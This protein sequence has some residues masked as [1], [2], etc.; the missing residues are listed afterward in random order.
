MPRRRGEKRIDSAAQLDE[1]SDRQPRKRGERCRAGRL[2]AHPRRDQGERVVRLHDDQMVL[3]GKPLA[4]HDLHHLPGPWME[5]IED[6]APRT[7]DTRHCD[8]VSTGTGKTHIALGLG[9]AACQ[10][11][12]SVGFTTAA[13]LVHELIEARDE[14]RLLRL[15]RQ[16]AGL[17]AADHRRARLRA[18]VA[19]RRRV[20]V[21]GVLAALRARLAPSSPATCRS[22]NG[23]PCSAPSA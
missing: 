4:V 6:P 17:Q 14:K 18:A 2:L 23:H 21:R 11:G 16:L 13:A 5:R 19:D 1:P 8:A 20:A 12:L 9:L 22:T 15:Q 7:P 3:A 10:K